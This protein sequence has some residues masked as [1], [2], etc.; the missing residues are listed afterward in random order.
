MRKVIQEVRERTIL[1]GM[2]MLKFAIFNAV[3][4]LVWLV[5]FIAGH[6]PAALVLWISGAAVLGLL[7]F[8]TRGQ[9]LLIEID[10]AEARA[11]AI[12]RRILVVAGLVTGAI[13]AFALVL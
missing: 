2:F 9:K 7:A 6:G 1:G 12:Q 4:V 13:M 3:M 10:V 11:V 5:S 8:L